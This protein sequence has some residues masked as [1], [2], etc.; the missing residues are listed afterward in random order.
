MTVNSINTGQMAWMGDKNV[1]DNFQTVSITTFTITIIASE[2]TWE[3]MEC[4]QRN[5]DFT[6]FFLRST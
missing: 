2:L 6:V 1:S 3:Q 4:C 5:Y